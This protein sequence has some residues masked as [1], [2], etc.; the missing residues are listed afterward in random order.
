[1][2]RFIAQSLLDRLEREWRMIDPDRR[3]ATVSLPKEEDSVPTRRLRVGRF[4][5]AEVNSD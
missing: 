5:D 1:M 2:T 3:S 4:D